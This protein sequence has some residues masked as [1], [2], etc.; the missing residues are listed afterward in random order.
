MLVNLNSKLIATAILFLTLSSCRKISGVDELVRQNPPS[1]N[2]EISVFNTGMLDPKA[3]LGKKIFFDN[4]LSQPIGMS[5]ASCHMPTKGFFAPGDVA[6]GEGSFRFVGGIAQGALGG[7]VFGNRKAPTAAYASFSPVFA[8]SVTDGEFSGGLFWDGRATGTRLGSPAA[9]QALGPFLNPKEHNLASKVALLNKLKDDAAYVAL[10]NTVWNTNINTNN[11]KAVD[12]EFDR[13]GLSIAAYEASAEVNPFSSKYDAVLRGQAQLTEIEEQGRQLFIGKGECYDCHTPVGV[14]NLPPMFTNFKY[15]NIGVPKNPLNPVYW[16]NPGFIDKGLGGF[17]ET[18]S[19]STWKSRSKAHLGKFKN[20]TIRNVGK[21]ER[22]MH[23][24]VFT[25]LA[26]VV[27]FYNTRDVPGE[28]WNGVPWGAP[29]MTANMTGHRKVGR[30]GLTAQ[31]EAA[32]VAF[33][34]TLSDG[35]QGNE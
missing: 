22:F 31:E 7:N 4:N 12:T 23:N 17:L 25:S 18:S 20:P 27:H 3:E 30:L 34:L 21:A 35:W 16:T 14:G 8:Y 6:Q 15:A 28:G 5:C 32:I 24:G 9:E 26:E 2:D 1:P 29:E 11:N 33:M 13:V 10:W 19:V